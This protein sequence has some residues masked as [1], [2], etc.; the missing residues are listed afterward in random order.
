MVERAIHRHGERENKYTAPLPSPDDR[1]RIREE[2]GLTQQDV[3]DELFVSRW[4]VA[5]WE[6]PAGYWNG[7]RS[8]GREPVG[9]LRTA[10]S[11]LLKELA[12]LESA[13]RQYKL[14][15]ATP[16]R[17]ATAGSWKL[18]RE[19]RERREPSTNRW[20]LVAVE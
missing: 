16:T 6:D 2:A 3:A 18:C 17:A 8:P 9:G 11:G 19:P 10:Y 20:S 14:V 4:T 15:E 12:V 13:D 7:Q 5:R 1:K